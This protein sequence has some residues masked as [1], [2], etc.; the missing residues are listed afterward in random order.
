M[1]VREAASLA[2]FHADAK[3]TRMFQERALLYAKVLGDFRR[4]VNLGKARRFEPAGLDVFLRRHAR[5]EIRPPRRAVMD[6]CDVG[7]SSYSL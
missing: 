6:F 1:I 5:T 3:A 2:Y 7:T 4:G